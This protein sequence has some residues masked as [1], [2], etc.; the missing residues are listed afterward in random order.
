MDRAT[1]DDGPFMDAHRYPTV[2]HNFP[3]SAIRIALESCTPEMR[4][5]K[6]TIEFRMLTV[7]SVVAES[8]SLTKAAAILGVTQ[9]AVSQTIK[10]LEG[11][12]GATLLLRRSR[13]VR[14]TTAGQ[15][16]YDHASRLLTDGQRMIAEVQM[17]A[18]QR[19]SELSIGIIDSLGCVISQALVKQIKPLTTKV[20]LRTGVAAPLTDSFLNREL[21]I[22]ITSDPMREQPDL[23]RFPILRDPFVVVA[24][25][26]RIPADADAPRWL[27][28]HIPFV[29]FSRE[30]LIGR[31]ADLVARRLEIG[32][33]TNYE[34]DNTETILRFVQAGHG[35][36][37]ITALCLAH[38]PQILRG[39]IVLPLAAGAH[40]RLI[41]LYSHR[42]EFGELPHKVVRICRGIC[43]KELS[44]VLNDIAPWLA[45][46]FSILPERRSGVV[47]PSRATV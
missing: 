45:Q 28:D 11:Q 18:H 19:L 30:T 9:S 24:P 36:T 21:D 32:L 6:S 2:L 12:I 20:M 37:I 23:E 34:F 8:Q 5:R 42:D 39:T 16:L 26:G 10:H 14:L 46:Q 29:R 40:T 15:V 35:W 41:A 47:D 33:A 44:P 3:H 22:L 7:F 38:H 43:E 27:A 13:P 25:A 4:F 31:T 1:R 17:A